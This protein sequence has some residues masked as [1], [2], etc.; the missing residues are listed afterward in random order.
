M[1]DVINKAKEENP[2][3]EI[4]EE[5]L[6]IKLEDQ[7][8]KVI[9]LMEPVL[10]CKEGSFDSFK[11]RLMSYGYGEPSFVRTITFEE[12]DSLVNEE[13]TKAPGNL[14]SLDDLDNEV[15]SA[16]RFIKKKAHKFLSHGTVSNEYIGQLNEAEKKMQEYKLGQDTKDK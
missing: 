10:V 4:P 12:L 14:E 1:M 8:E 15:N 7:G 16:L 6:P 13:L 2:D 9:R 11:D 3:K 5:L